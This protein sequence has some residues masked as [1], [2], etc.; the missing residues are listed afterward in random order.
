[1]GTTGKR[2]QRKVATRR[3]IIDAAVTLAHRDGLNAV[4][5]E[6]I[7]SVAGVSPATVFNYFPSKVAI[8]FADTH[9]YRIGD[10]VPAQTTPWRTVAHAI[11]A[12]IDNPDWTRPLDD[13]LTRQRFE[14]VQREPELASTQISLLFSAV[15][16][17]A[18]AL[19]TSHPE[20]SGEAATAISGAAIGA[21][22]AA[23]N[24]NHG[25][26]RAR[27]GTALAVLADHR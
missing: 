27:L 17:L 2:E 8:F 1:M 15:P 21:V 7:A 25:D 5:V 14:I 18:H 4:T 24:H 20:L 10:V 12:A 23:L 22:A 9:L 11:A 3:A 26:L 16:T 19:R 13:R 6:Q